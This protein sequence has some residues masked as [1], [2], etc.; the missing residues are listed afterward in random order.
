MWSGFLKS[1]GMVSALAWGPSLLGGA[2]SRSPR[3]T[4]EVVLRG[5]SIQ[6]GRV[7]VQVDSGGCT[8]KAS[9]QARVQREAGTAGQPDR[10]TLTFER[11]R[12]DDCKAFLP[13]GVRLEYDLARDL[14][15]HGRCQVTVANPVETN[16]AAAVPAKD[17]LKAA[18]LAA[19]RKAIDLE[20][21]GYESRLEAARKGLGPASNVA[22]FEGR[23]AE[24]KARLERFRNLPVTEY[25]DPVAVPPAEPFGAEGSYGPVVPAREM[26]IRVKPTTRY[27]EGSLLEAEG[28]TR[29]GPFYHLAGGEYAS[30]VP[31][32]TYEVTVYLVYRREYVSFIPDG[33]VYVAEVK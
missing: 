31:G 19:T 17:A 29:S 8:D 27:R 16:L 23:V 18:L 3:E 28:T 25:P 32:H 6:P 26:A 10:V 12:P 7:I 13:G 2:P 9:I 33:Y 11:I 4:G 1:L 21:E 30:L 14:G 15:L 22:R 24:A 20:L 5:V